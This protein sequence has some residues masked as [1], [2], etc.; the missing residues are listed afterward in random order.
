MLVGLNSWQG[1]SNEQLFPIVIIL[2]RERFD[3][4]FK[5]FMPWLF[6]IETIAMV[7]PRPRPAKILKMGPA[8]VAV[9]AISE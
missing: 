3:L 2:K 9:T 4:T 7:Y 1:E 8:I 6:A 5:M